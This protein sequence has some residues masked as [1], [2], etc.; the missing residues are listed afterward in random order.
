MSCDCYET[1]NS[2]LS[3]HNTKIASYFTFGS[4]RI[5]RPWPIET[6][7]VAT[8]RGKAKAVSLIASYCPMCGVSLRN[9]DEGEE[10]E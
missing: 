2:K 6:R 1:V 5:G 7:Q 3:V 9:E 10:E 4:N 8:G